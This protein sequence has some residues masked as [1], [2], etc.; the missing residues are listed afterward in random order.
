MYHLV[1]S[2]GQ[3]LTDSIFSFDGDTVRLARADDF[4]R[5][6]EVKYDLIWS[7]PLQIDSIS[8]AIRNTRSNRYKEKTNF[9][10]VNIETNQLYEASLSLLDYLESGIG[11]EI[12]YEHLRHVVITSDLSID[13]MRHFDKDEVKSFIFTVGVV[14][15]V[16]ITP[17]LVT[18]GI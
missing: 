18:R 12:N 8:Y 4:K 7:S 16:N 14:G 17:F 9:Y 2:Q 15:E 13:Y 5:R 6:D 1:E 11:N 3:V 10:L